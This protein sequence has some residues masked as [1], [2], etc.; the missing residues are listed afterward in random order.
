LR[1]P[2]ADDAERH[3][4]DAAERQAAPDLLNAEVI[5]ALRRFERGGVI[6][7]EVA[8]GA[9]ETLAQLPIARYPTATLLDRAW[10]LRH[11]FTAYD[12][13]YVALAEAVGTRLVTTDERL[14]SAVRTHTGIEVVLL[15]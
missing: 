5:H 1:L 7:A 12:A 4:F 13:M 8:T 10:S 6:D 11:N 15:A 3:V 9:V 2:R 14:S